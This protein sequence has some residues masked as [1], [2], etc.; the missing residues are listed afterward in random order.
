MNQELEESRFQIIEHLSRAIEGRDK[1][2]G[3][4]V[5][6]VSRYAFVIG[7]FLGEQRQHAN[8]IG[9]SQEDIQKFCRILES[10]V[11]MHDV[12]KVAIPDSILLKPG[13]PNAKER[14]IL[15][16]HPE[17]G[18]KIF[19]GAED[20]LLQTAR[21]IA[22]MHHEFWNGKGYPNKIKGEDILL[23]GR[24]CAVADVF[25]ALTSERPYKPAWPFEKAI[26]KIQEGSGEEFDPAVVRA[27]LAK[28]D[29]IRRIM[30]ENRDDPLPIAPS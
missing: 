4:H 25:D 18:A 8:V 29:E 19:D 23:V 13:R 28:Q 14:E 24:I 6:R 7:K 17:K 16:T 15:N 12:G 10:A 1:H 26:A 11:L 30:N 3:L 2:T 9:H 22:L 21:V 5:Q 20:K 27:F